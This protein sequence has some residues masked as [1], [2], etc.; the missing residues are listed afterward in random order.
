[1]DNLKVWFICLLV[2]FAGVVPAK[3]KA[4]IVTAVGSGTTRSEALQ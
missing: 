1:M 4:I 3:D 2:F